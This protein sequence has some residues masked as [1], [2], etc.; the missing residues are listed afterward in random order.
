MP[1]VNYNN[2]PSFRRVA[3]E[4]LDV[5]SPTEAKHQD[6][7]ELHI[8]F[9]NMMPDAAFLATERQ[10][11]RLAAASTNIVQIYIH[12]IHCEGVTRNTDIAEHIAKYYQRFD[13][14]KHVGLDALIVTGANPKLRDLTQED[15]WQHATEIF[16]WAEH[17]VV[18]V[19]FS[20][21]ASHAVL[22][23]QYD[24]TRQPVAEKIWGVYSHRVIAPTHPLVANINTRFDMPHSR[25]NDISAERFTSQG[26]PILACSDHVGVA[27][28]TSKDGFRQIFCQGHPEYDTASL[29][30]EY[31]R[32][33]ARFV[34]K[35]RSDYPNFPINYG[36]N[37]IAGL[38]QQYAQQLRSGDTNLTAF[39]AEKILSFV[40]NTWRDTAKAI[41]SNWLALVYRVTHVER[42]KQFMDGIDPDNPIARWYSKVM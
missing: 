12:P 35:E 39:P 9:L 10:F 13:N 37:A 5:L 30:K 16:D 34:A 11:F 3:N 42:D 2:H 6:I 26:L 17:N 1:I 21:L 33:L 19:F 7:R 24:L 25:G 28:A 38:L 15:Y 29:L 8:G 14:I 22:Q 36:S 32:E 20:C 4:G 40:D 31:Q 41:F 18:S 27:L 23:A